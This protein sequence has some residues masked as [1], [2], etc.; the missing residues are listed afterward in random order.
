[1]L[2][3]GCL[4]QSA[5]VST[6]SVKTNVC[7]SAGNQ[8][9]GPGLALWRTPSVWSRNPCVQWGPYCSSQAAGDTTQDLRG[10]L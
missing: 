3:S 4:A 2:W 1:M 6:L 7:N 9:V 10:G 5:W 8:M